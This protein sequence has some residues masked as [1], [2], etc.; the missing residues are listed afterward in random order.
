MFEG[1]T[2][3]EIG[4]AITYIV[5][6]LVILFIVLV[7]FTFLP[8]DRD[9]GMFR[10]T[11]TPQPIM[12][13]QS[14]TAQS[15]TPAPTTPDVVYTRN[16]GTNRV[17]AIYDDELV[18][19]ATVPLRISIPKVGVNSIIVHP[20]SPRVD[21]LDEALKKGVV[22]YPGSGTIEQGNIFLFGHSSN[23]AIVQNQAYKIFN[24]IEKLR[25]GDEIFL[26]ADGKRY[27]YSVESVT[28]VD[29]NTAF[30]DLSRDGR[31]LTLSTCNTFGRQS[32]RW[33]VDAVFK[34]VR[35]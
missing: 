11:A 2:S 21:V 3:K 34:E 27:V 7:V 29:A 1:K 4:D 5:I 24:N 25:I 14:I 33:V 19:T 18:T 35:E 26:T 12:Y 23:W 20:N 6:V 15:V 9:G 17:Q 31:R 28:M 30:V 16:R 10:P 8:R 13:D 32:D 22:Y